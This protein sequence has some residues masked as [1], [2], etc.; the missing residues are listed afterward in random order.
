MP[1]CLLSCWPQACLS[2]LPLLSGLDARRQICSQVH[3]PALSH[4]LDALRAALSAKPDAATELRQSYQELP[5]RHG[6]QLLQVAEEE[7]PLLR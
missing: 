1:P 7:L 3:L 2:V 6:Q 5:W 4:L